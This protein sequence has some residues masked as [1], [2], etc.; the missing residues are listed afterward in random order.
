[1]LYARQSTAECGEDT[2]AES[3]A[4]LIV[5]EGTQRFLC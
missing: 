1:M 3:A 2:T 4:S 5:V